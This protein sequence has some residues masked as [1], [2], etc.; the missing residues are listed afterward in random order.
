MPGFPDGVL[1]FI[2]LGTGTSSSIPQVDCLTAPHDREPCRACLSGFNGHIRD[3][4]TMIVSSMGPT[5]E[6]P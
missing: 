5:E 2:F 4:R 3:V 1:E 6:M